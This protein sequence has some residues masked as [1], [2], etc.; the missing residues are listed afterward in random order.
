LPSSVAKPNGLIVEGGVNDIVHG[1]SAV[2]LE[3]VTGSIIRDIESKRL[4]AILLTVS[5]F[6]NNADWTQALEQIRLTYNRW[7]LAQ[8]S[9]QNGIYVYDMAAAASAGGLADDGNPTL[10][11]AS[12]DS[13]DGLH[14]NLAGGQRIATELKQI[15]DEI[16]VK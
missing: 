15:L 10:L 14:P 8:A 12:F 4:T 11:A 3:A 2:E 9:A 13:G 16:N 7:L 5:P 1:S 6:G